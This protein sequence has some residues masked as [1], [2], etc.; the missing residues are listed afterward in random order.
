MHFCRNVE[1]SQVRFYKCN[2]CDY[3]CI[4]VGSLRTHK[5]RFLQ[6]QPSY[7]KYHKRD[8]HALFAVRHAL[9]L[10]LWGNT[11]TTHCRKATLWT[12]F[13]NLNWFRIVCYHVPFQSRS[14]CC[15][16]I[17]ESAVQVILDLSWLKKSNVAFRGFHNLHL[18]T[19]NWSHVSVQITCVF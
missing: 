4:F 14:F 1:D 15:N 18:N 2:Q 10:V 17:T 6:I 12:L 8:S 9:I 19:V 7:H 3:K 16:E 5:K 13:F 11:S